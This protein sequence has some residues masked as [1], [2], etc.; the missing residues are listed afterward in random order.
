MKDSKYSSNQKITVAID[1][2]IFGFDS[3]KL[4]LLLFKRR[5]NPF[6][7]SWSLVGEVLENDLSLDRSANEILY[8]L[9]GLK[10][11]YLKQLKT[12]D[13]SAIK[14]LTPK[15]FL[16]VSLLLFVIQPSFGQRKKRKEKEPVLAYQ[17]Q[18]YS[19]LKYRSIGPHRG[20]R[21]AAV[22]G[23][24]GKPNLFYFG[25]TGGGVW[26][27][28]DGG[29]TYENISDGYFGGSIGSVSVSLSD[30]NVIYVGGGEVTLR[31]NVSSG[32]G[33][34]KSEDAGKTWA[35]RAYQNPDTSPE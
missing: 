7:G 10:N 32:Y 12:N 26:K 24:P 29:Q 35:F 19:S 23:V 13:M 33:M 22:T 14:L 11:I 4:N 15:L 3:E 2:V 25:A 20:G 34:W 9:T 17:E 18:V 27:T 21:S 16:S 28:E 6:K 30:P 31:G 8:K 5:V 1:C